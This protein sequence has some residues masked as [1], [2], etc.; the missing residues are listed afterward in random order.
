MVF[1]NH[2]QIII[3]KLLIERP[4]IGGINQSFIGIIGILI[5]IFFSILIT[6]VANSSSKYPS[7]FIQKLLDDKKT[8]SF[9]FLLVLLSIVQ[10]LFYHF[11]FSNVLM[12]TFFIIV[13]FGSLFWYWRYILNFIDPEKTIEN[14]DENKL[15]KE[16][17]SNLG[18]YIKIGIESNND[19]M[20]DKAIQ[21]LKKFHRKLKNGQ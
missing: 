16:D 3:E 6:I 14:I 5:A 12:D 8:R 15:A 2:S 1:G 21:K 10:V 9:Y 18:D 19:T 11:N 4:E 20:T 17:I 13:I 7:N